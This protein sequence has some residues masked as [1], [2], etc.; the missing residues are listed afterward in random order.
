MYKKDLFI[1]AFT[2]YL[3]FVLYFCC[4]SDLN[5]NFNN[6]INKLNELTLNK[7]NLIDLNKTF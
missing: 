3:V 6:L 1:N 2:N 5:K 7:T 4:P